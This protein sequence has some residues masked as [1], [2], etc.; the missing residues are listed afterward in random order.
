MA[1]LFSKSQAV[2]GLSFFV[3]GADNQR[4][5]QKSAVKEQKGTKQGDRIKAP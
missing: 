5:K 3:L 4:V 2:F 1:S